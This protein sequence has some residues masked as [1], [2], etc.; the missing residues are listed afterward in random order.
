VPLASYEEANSHLDG[1]KIAFE[2]EEDA[3]NEAREADRIVRGALADTFPEQV[4]YW[5]HELPEPVLEALITPELV[6]LVASLLMASYKYSM[7]YSEDDLGENDY[8]AR[9]EKRA[10]K[11]LK[12]IQSG[13]A[14]L[15]D[16]EYG[17]TIADSYTLEQED[18][19]PNDTYTEEYVRQQEELQE[20]GL[21]P[22]RKFSMDQRL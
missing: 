6:R 19:W 14:V 13:D 12:D 4:G 20:A 5:V 16:V 8:S 2:S 15:W 10:M 11:I 9:L 3:E 7:H 22:A 21:G 17:P 18:F 1:T